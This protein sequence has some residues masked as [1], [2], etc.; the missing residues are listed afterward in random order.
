MKFYHVYNPIT[1][2]EEIW[3]AEPKLMSQIDEWYNA[4]GEYIELA[5]GWL[6]NNLGETHDVRTVLPIE[7]TVSK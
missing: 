6:L 3:N 7:I 5:P 1:L 2:V 4:D